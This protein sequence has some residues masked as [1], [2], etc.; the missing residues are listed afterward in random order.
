M[1]LVNALLF[2]SGKRIWC[3]KDNSWVEWE[4]LNRRFVHPV[5]KSRFLKPLNDGFI[6][7]N[8]G[9]FA[10][11]VV[12]TGN[13]FGSGWTSA[14]VVENYLAAADGGKKR[15]ANPPPEPP[16]KMKGTSESYTRHILHLI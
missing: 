9:T 14:S 13:V 15:K 12:E 3:C 4:G 16:K 7:A 1:L 10:S 6:W 11:A 5:H 8:V 2:I